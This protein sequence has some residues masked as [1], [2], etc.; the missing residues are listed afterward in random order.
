M[1]PPPQPLQAPGFALDRRTRSP[2]L[3]P[4]LLGRLPGILQQVA[5]LPFGLGA[6]CL[7]RP[8]GLL[9]GP[10]PL[11]TKLL[12]VLAG[13]TLDL[14]GLCLSGGDDLGRFSLGPIDGFLGRSAASTRSFS[15]D[16]P[17]SSMMSAT[18]EPRWLNDGVP[19]ASSCIRY[20]ACSA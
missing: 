3:L 19:R 17:A 9:R 8:A 5:G 10:G 11:D 20:S 18:W 16:R 15:A 7:G 2:R 4:E 6:E 12:G 1:G 14:A 13:G